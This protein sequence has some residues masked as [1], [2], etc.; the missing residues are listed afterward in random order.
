[1]SKCRVKCYLPDIRIPYIQNG[2]KFIF[3][4]IFITS[5]C[6]YL[7]RNIFNRDTL[8]HS[9]YNFVLLHAVNATWVAPSSFLMGP[10]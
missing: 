9:D 6:M 1:M 2:I 5:T 10:F 4:V 7:I 3:V 8:T